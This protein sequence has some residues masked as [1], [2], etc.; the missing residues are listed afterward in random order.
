MIEIL[1]KEK[2][3]L[4]REYAIRVL[5]HNIINMILYPGQTLNENEIAE[6]ISVSRTPVREAI[7][8]LAKEGIIE[9]YPQKG[10]CVAPI[11]LETINE[12]RFLRE[13]V[14]LALCEEVTKYISEEEILKLEEVIRL[15]EFYASKREI[16]KLLESDNKFHYL[17]FEISHKLRTYKALEGLMGHFQRI[18]ML[19]L[20]NI[21]SENIII[22]HKTIVEAIKTKDPK[23]AK[24][25]MHGHLSRVLQDQ[26]VLKEQYSQYFK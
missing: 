15:Q 7:I 16:V 17:L 4:A 18:R 1:E 10:T 9:I 3:E 19:S 6:A 5:R 25:V 11:D 14:E 12:A 21:N 13:T 24:E 23:L 8:T 2:Q 26:E 20:N 22:E